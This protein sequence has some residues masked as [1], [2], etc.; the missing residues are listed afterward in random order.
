MNGRGDLDRID[1]V[2]LRAWR[3]GNLIG[4]W[5]V[6]TVV[7]HAIAIVLALTVVQKI[8]LVSFGR[9]APTNML[10]LFVALNFGAVTA[11]TIVGSRVYRSPFVVAALAVLLPEGI[12]YL[13]AVA[14]GAWPEMV[15]LVLMAVT[16]ATIAG[17]WARFV[18]RR[19]PRA[20][21]LPG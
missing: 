9:S 19:R 15:V 20:L 12:L 4:W 13:F 3:A 1:R 10:V 17:I 2:T 7:F 14:G 16:P 6:G 11:G 18:W 5:F 8:A 21:R